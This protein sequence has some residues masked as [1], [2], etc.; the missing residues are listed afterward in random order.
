MADFTHTFARKLEVTHWGKAVEAAFI[1]GAVFLIMQMLLLALF[2]GQSPMEPARRIAAIV[3][4]REVLWQTGFD[5]WVLIA[6]L[7]VNFGLATL[8]AWILTPIVAEM[9]RPWA[10]ATGAAFGLVLYVVNFHLM[11]GAFPW[12]RASRDWITVLNHLIFGIVL[13]WSYLRL[14][15]GY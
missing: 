13:A 8:F 15:F 9:R 12:F 10:L 7:L 5:I 11:T 14:R 3:M 4:G 1:A 6:A 2:E